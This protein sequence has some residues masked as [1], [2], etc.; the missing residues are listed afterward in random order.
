MQRPW[1]ILSFL[2][3]PQLRGDS[4]RLCGVSQAELRPG[5]MWHGVLLPLSAA[6]APQPDVWP[7]P[8]AASPPHVRRHRC[9]HAVR[10]QWRTRRRWHLLLS[11]FSALEFFFF[12][13]SG[14]FIPLCW[15]NIAEGV[16]T[17]N[18][19]TLLLKMQRRS[20]RALAAVPTSW[21]P[22]TAA[23]TAW[24]ALCVPVS[25]AGCVCRRSPMCTTS[26]NHERINP[27]NLTKRH[28]FRFPGWQ[29]IKRLNQQ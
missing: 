9:L 8:A 22:M 17:P 26:G 29:A 7:G 11:Y 4:L 5:G 16:V 3:S 14:H 19:L 23:V 10:L 15:M 24:T 25:S 6:V 13:F 20:K 18:T 12:F 1:S 21:R 27:P 28:T 2:I